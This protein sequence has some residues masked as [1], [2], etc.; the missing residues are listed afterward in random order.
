ML[1]VL[2][3]VGNKIN[4]YTQ[5]AEPTGKDGIWV[6][7]N[8]IIDNVQYIDEL[9]T[10]INQLSNIPRPTTS[11]IN[12][13]QFIYYFNGIIYFGLGGSSYKTNLY[14]YNIATNTYSNNY[15]QVQWDGYGSIYG[16]T[17]CPFR[18]EKIMVL[19]VGDANSTRYFAVNLMNSGSSCTLYKQQVKNCDWSTHD[20]YI[21]SY[22]APYNDYIYGFSDPTLSIYNRKIYRHNFESFSTGSSFSVTI[23]DTLMPVEIDKGFSAV[24]V[25]N[26]IYLICTDY[27]VWKFDPSNESFTKLNASLNLS[28]SSRSVCLQPIDDKIFIVDK[29]YLKFIYYDVNADSYFT[30]GNI[31][32]TVLGN[33]VA[34]KYNNEY[35]LYTINGSSYTAMYKFTLGQDELTNGLVIINGNDYKTKYVGDVP[36][37]YNQVLK[38][39]N[40][41]LSSPIVYNGNGTEWIEIQGE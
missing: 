27:S 25:G 20:S 9:P 37:H 30:V 17:W 7:T 34:Y 36:L 4:L 33:Y 28:T 31:T 21:G 14:K 15:G 24:T 13:T 8:E 11:S 5:T 35:Y 23:L 10:S 16:G 1:Q 18:N 38:Y 32:D 22:F 29:T 19:S 3:K 26:Y 41:V 2:M 40:S 39:N 12:A 6:K